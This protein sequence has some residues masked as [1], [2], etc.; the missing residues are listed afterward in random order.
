MDEHLSDDILEALQGA[1]FEAL[2]EAQQHAVE[3]LEDEQ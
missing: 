1:P 2:T 3:C